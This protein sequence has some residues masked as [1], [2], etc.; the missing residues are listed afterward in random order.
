MSNTILNAPVVT[1]EIITAACKKFAGENIFSSDQANEIA[2]HYHRHSDGYELAKDLE[3]YCWWDISCDTVENLD[4]V[5]G[6]VDDE[7][8]KCRKK[9][10]EA[11]NIQPPFPIGAELKEGVITGIWDNDVAY[12]QV[13]ETGCTNKSRSLLIKFENA[14]LKE[15]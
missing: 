4:M 13:K 6:Y 12:Y 8:K 1:K 11:N 5:S 10:F 2:Q 9:W 15:S 3:R 7:Y 14:E